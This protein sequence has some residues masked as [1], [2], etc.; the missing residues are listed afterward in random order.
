MFNQ[1][2]VDWSRAV[3]DAFGAVGQWGV[4]F[5]RVVDGTELSLQYEGFEPSG[6]GAVA[7]FVNLVKGLLGLW[8]DLVS[9]L[10]YLLSTELIVCVPPNSIA[11]LL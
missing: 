9:D 1:L 6:S 3:R 4:R 5:G 10:A 2:V 11:C 8:T 7:S